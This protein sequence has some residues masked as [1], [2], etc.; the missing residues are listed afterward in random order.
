MC[1]IAG[2]V[3]RDGSPVDSAVLERLAAAMAHRGPDGVGAHLAGPMGLVNTRLAIIDLETG[4]QP[5][6]DEAHAVL[7]ANGEVYND[8]EIRADPACTPYATGSDCESVLKLYR[9]DGAGLMQDLRGMYAIALFDPSCGRLLLARDPFGIKQL[10]LAETDAYLAFA[11]EAK[12][13][14]EAGLAG[15]GLRPTARA[16]LAQLKFTTGRQTI[17]S[18]IQRLLPGEL[19]ALADGRVVERRRRAALP[20]GG[21][22]AGD[23]EALLAALDRVLTDTV[24]HH[25]RSDV[26]YGLFLSGGIDSSVLVALMARLTDQPVYALTAGF[27][28]SGGADE[29]ALAGRVARSVGADHH[30]IEVGEDD[31][32][33]FA[34][35]VAACLDDPT[36]DAAALP[37][38]MLARA[39]KGGMTVV[40]SGEGADEMFGGYSRYRRARLFGALAGRSRTRGVFRGGVAAAAALRGWR[41]G[42]ARAEVEV[43][44]PGRTTMQRLQAADCAEWLP[45]DL[46]VKLDRC[47]MAHSL[48]GRTPYLDPVVADFAFRLPDR[49]KARGRMGKWLLREWLARNVPAAEPFARK[50]GFNP[51]V[52]TWIAARADRLGDLVAAQ[53]GVAEFLPARA[54]RAVIADAADNSQAAWSLVFYALWHTHH[55]LGLPADGAIDEVLAAAGRGG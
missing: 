19:I 3:M 35:E 12:A 45:N 9:R 23:D 6:F 44:H 5:L 50:S 2:I 29:T 7:V 27:A 8:P 20:E 42:L 55:V 36:T 40:L 46:L 11:S 54:V 1:G 4:D 26:P 37:T 13:L 31:F 21:P 18:D 51:P 49:A 22:I 34:P 15:R 48:E 33:R 30:V 43:A 10:Y 41:D 47:L 17:F 32:W 14:I 52:G 28:G 53:P 38:W 24:A 16:E 25:L 39:A